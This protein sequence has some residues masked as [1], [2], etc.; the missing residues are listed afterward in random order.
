MAEL[1][2]SGLVCT[3]LFPNIT[4]F[5]TFPNGE[6]VREQVKEKGKALTKFGLQKSHMQ[7]KS[8][9]LLLCF[10]TLKVFKVS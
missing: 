10:T 6:K 9:G 5:S 7:W 1:S 4:C 3:A 2:P 8:S